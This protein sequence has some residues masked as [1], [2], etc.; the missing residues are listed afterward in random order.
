MAEKTQDNKFL[1]FWIGVLTGALLV[2]IIFLY[3]LYGAE[4]G[5]ANLF[6]SIQYSA[7]KITTQTMRIVSP[8]T[9]VS[10]GDPQP[11]APVAS[12]DPQPWAPVASGDPQP[13]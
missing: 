1:L 12:G 6:R 7:P 5:G 4:T 10:S 13:W 2:G 11:W 8:T 3:R 9:T